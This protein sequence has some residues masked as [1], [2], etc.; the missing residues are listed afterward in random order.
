MR[1]LMRCAR[2]DGNAFGDYAEGQ[3]FV[4]ATMQVAYALQSRASAARPRRTTAWSSRAAAKRPCHQRL[5]T[6]WSMMV[7]AALT[8][9]GGDGDGIVDVVAGR[10]WTVAAAVLEAVPCPADPPERAECAYRRPELGG[11]DFLDRQVP[12]PAGCPQPLRPKQARRALAQCVVGKLVGTD[13]SS[14]TL[15]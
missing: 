6:F 15:A 3:L 10:A 2:A 12:A 13:R 7:V 4:A 11:D 14:A 9:L 5:R 1:K 8:C